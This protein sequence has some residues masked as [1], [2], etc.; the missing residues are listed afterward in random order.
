MSVINGESIVKSVQV[1]SDM[2][3]ESHRI[4]HVFIC[5]PGQ[6]VPDSA[7]LVLLRRGGPIALETA[8][9]PEGYEP[10][11]LGRS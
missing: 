4:L 8:S 2:P 3:C 9:L 5:R 6:V 7:R 10:K 11:L 1:A